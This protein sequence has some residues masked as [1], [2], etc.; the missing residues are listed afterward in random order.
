V[1][2][3]GERDRHHRLGQQDEGGDDATMIAERRRR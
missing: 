3:A 2:V 1:P